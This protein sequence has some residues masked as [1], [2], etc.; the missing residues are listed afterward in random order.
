MFMMMTATCEMIW[1]LRFCK[2][3]KFI[4]LQLFLVKS[5]TC[6]QLLLPSSEPFLLAARRHYGTQFAIDQCV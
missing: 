2:L 6:C 4:K 5:S 3:Y 1:G